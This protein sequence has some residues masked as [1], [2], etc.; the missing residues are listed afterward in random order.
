MADDDQQVIIRLIAILGFVDPVAARIAAEQDDLPDLA[1]LL[2]RLRGARDRDGK[3]VH[4]YLRRARQFF[5]LRGW[6]MINIVSHH[7]I[8][9]L[10]SPGGKASLRPIAVDL[11]RKSVV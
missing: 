5:L 10:F 6:E 11:D 8:L 7:R 9:A 2:P 1:V 4:Q 3:F